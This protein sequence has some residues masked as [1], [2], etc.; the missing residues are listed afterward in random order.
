M[1]V[2]KSPHPAFSQRIGLFGPLGRHFGLS[3]AGHCGV[4]LTFSLVSIPARH[5]GIDLP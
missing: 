2:A 3:H 1:P 4:I 5:F